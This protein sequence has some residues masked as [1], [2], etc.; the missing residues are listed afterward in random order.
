MATRIV[1]D[2]RAGRRAFRS[3][4]GRIPIEWRLDDRRLGALPT[5]LDVERAALLRRLRGD[6]ARADRN[7]ERWAHCPA[8]HDT[9]RLASDKHGVPVPRDVFVR[10]RETDELLLHTIRFL[11]VEHR[12]ADELALLQLDQPREVRL[13]R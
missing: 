1:Q 5:D 11:L 9:A 8:T 10:H 12:A 3:E 7:A 2:A 13:E 6:V 4:M